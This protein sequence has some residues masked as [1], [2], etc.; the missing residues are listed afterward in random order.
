[1]LV[2]VGGNT[3]VLRVAKGLPREDE[4]VVIWP[5]ALQYILLS[6][7]NRVSIYIPTRTKKQVTPSYTHIKES[8]ADFQV[9]DFGSIDRRDASPS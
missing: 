7:L 9:P 5:I 6:T 1:M 4:D 2:R 8:K 3:A